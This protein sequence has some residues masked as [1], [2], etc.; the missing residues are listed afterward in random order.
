MLHALSKKCIVR[1]FMIL[2]DAAGLFR[3]H[4]QFPFTADQMQV[5]YQTLHFYGVLNNQ[6]A[7]SLQG[8]SIFGR[9]LRGYN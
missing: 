7:F 1:G 3:K 4:T 5:A 8:F 9:N 2:A 6:S